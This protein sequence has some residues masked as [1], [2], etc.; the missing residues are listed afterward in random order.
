MQKNFEDGSFVRVEKTHETVQI[1]LGTVKKEG[2]MKSITT[3]S[4]ELSQSEFC[5]LI[6]DVCEKAPSRDI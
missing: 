5:E 6:R 4:V 1:V 3:T 2:V